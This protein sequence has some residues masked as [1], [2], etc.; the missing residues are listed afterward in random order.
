M[1]VSEAELRHRFQNVRSPSAG[2]RRRTSQ[3]LRHSELSDVKRKSRTP[4]VVDEQRDVVIICR[5]EKM[6]DDPEAMKRFSEPDKVPQQ[7]FVLFYGEGDS[8]L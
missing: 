5:Q 1:P 7:R 8:T 6:Q 2:D 4:Q 3:N